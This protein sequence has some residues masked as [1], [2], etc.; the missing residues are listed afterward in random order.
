MNFMD[1]SLLPVLLAANKY[2]IIDYDLPP[3]FGMPSGPLIF[4]GLVVLSFALG[5]LTANA[6]RMRDYG[7]KIGLILSTLFVSLFVVLVGEFKLGVDLKG[8]VILVYEVNELET[9]QLRRGSR[10]NEWNMGQLLGVITERLNPTGLKE[11][12]VRPFG[13]KQVEIVVP[14]VDP[15]EI[16]N[17]KEKIRTAGVLQFMIVASDEKDAELFAAASKQAERKDEDRLRRDVVDA[18]GRQVGYWAR[19]AREPGDEKTAAFR[20]LETLESGYIRDA[21]TGEIF[22]LTSQQKRLF[23]SS[24]SALEAFLKER[25]TTNIDVLMVFDPDFSIRGDD[26]SQAYAGHDEGFRPAIHFTMRTEGSIKMGHVTQEYLRRKLAIIFDTKL[27]SAPVIQSKISDNGQITGSFSQ[28]EVDFIVGILET[29]SMPVVMQKDPISENQI[30][31]I[32]GM[33][34]I[35]KGSWSVVIALALVLAFMALYYRAAGLIACFALA[36]NL[37]L[38]IGIMVLLQAPLTL[39]GLAGL[40]LT[41]AMSVDANVLISE[42]M[43][44][45]LARGATLRMA[46]RNGF[47]K[48]LSAIIDGNLTTFLTALVLYFIG[49]DQVKGFGMTLMLG[50]ITSMFTAIFCA[51]VILDVGERTRWLKTLSMASILTNPRVDWVRFFGPAVMGSF[52]LIVIGV[53]AT[54]ARGKGLFDTDLA[55]GSSVTFIL[56]QPVPEETMRQKLDAVFENLIDPKTKTRADHSVYE[57]TMEGQPKDTVYKIDSSLEEVTLLQQKVREAL[58][59]P[60][61]QD[62]LKTFTMEFGQ[63]EEAPLVVAPPAAPSLSAPGANKTPPVKGPAAPPAKTATKKTEEAKE[64]AATAVEAKTPAE[65]TPVPDAKNPPEAKDESPGCESEVQ[66][67]A[68]KS[69][70][71]AAKAIDTPAAKTNQAAEQAQPL[72][73]AAATS[74]PAT[75]TPAASVPPAASPANSAPPAE[76]AAASPKLKT[77]VVVRFPGSPISAAALQER[78]NTSAKESINEDLE[79]FVDNKDW[80][81]VDNATFE[82]WTVTLPVDQEKTGKVLA[83]AKTR[84]ENEVVWQTSSKIGGQVSADTRWRALGALAVSLLGIIAYVWFRF[85][86]VAWGLAAVAALAHDALVML[87]GIAVS[88][89]LAGPLGFLG[90][91]EFKISLPVVAAFLAILGYSVNDTIVIFDRLREIRGKSPRIT[92]E[93]LNASV[94]ETLSRTIIL[95]GIT[96]T[97]V[98]ILY[99]FGGPGIH[100][101]S[102]AMVVGVISGCYTTLVIASPMVLWLLNRQAVLTPGE[103]PN[104]QTTKSVA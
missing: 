49:T 61:G 84:L 33:D 58:K 4:L 38:T 28:E 103:V 71:D 76:A 14:E 65:S 74:S 5:I 1:A 2:R 37:L 24:Q 27:L 89:W 30:G 47:D 104:R 98:V 102:F 85:Q 73:P 62:G 94:N 50:N 53:I 81:R 82:E 9:A 19:L 18:D 40:V 101:F 64:K 67:E 57:L 8:G 60:D 72:E 26:L 21:R 13:P 70:P 15:A 7:W 66:E 92:R 34:T 68:A 90:V 25:G 43:R 36:L 16:E 42:R 48:A 69:A 55:G 87:T 75:G 46:I 97:V 11:I 41:V 79:I 99:A 39:P 78:L 95:A 12:V 63:L 3:I 6:A 17:I 29:G 59:S 88:Y 10:E 51:R 96:L 100:A 23:I 83:H 35:K 56:K 80:D 52:V 93:M 91:E 32:L 77:K 31:A 44:E 86:N 22:D 20:A 54:V 45:E